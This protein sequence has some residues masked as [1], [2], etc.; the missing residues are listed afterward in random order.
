MTN[1][2]AILDTTFLR[3]EL[4][5]KTIQSIQPSLSEDVILLIGDQNKKENIINQNPNWHYTYHYNLPFDCG[6]SYGRNFLVDKAYKL[7]CKYCLI[8]A[9]SILFTDKYDFN[10][11]IETME[12]KNIGLVGLELKNRVYWNCD[13]SLIEKEHFLLDAPKREQWIC[14]GIIYQPCDVVKNFFIA[15]TETLMDIQWDKNLKLAE[16]EDFFWRYSRKYK[17]YFTDYIN[18]TY[19]GDKYKKGE[20]AQYRSRIGKF[21]Q[22]AKEK[23]NLSGYWV[24]TTDLKR[25]FNEWR[26]NK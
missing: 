1:T 12:Y 10:P 20:Y 8:T 25:K 13:I 18:A 23:Y 5:F 17:V 15:K 3:N 14:D 26:N 2:I 22:L 7:G 4:A 9:D 11:I 24:Y 6:L 21:R 16:H 19:I